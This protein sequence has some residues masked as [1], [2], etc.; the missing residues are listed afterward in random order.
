MLP[1]LW[2]GKSLIQVIA[3]LHVVPNHYAS[4]TSNLYVFLYSGDNKKKSGDA[5]G[6]SS[7]SQILGILLL[8]VSLCFDGG[9]GAY[10]DKLMSVH[11]VQPFDLMYNIQLGKTILAGVALLGSQSSARLFAND[12]RNGLFAP[13]ARTVGCHGTSF[14]FHY[15]F[16]IWCPHV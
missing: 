3:L 10:E 4:F 14:H 5:D 7:G 6:G 9:T 8:F 11:S 15:H 2:E 16:Q 13:L 12:S 1:C